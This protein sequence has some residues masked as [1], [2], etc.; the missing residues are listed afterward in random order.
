MEWWQ[1][2]ILGIVEGV[3]EFLPVSSTGHLIIAS[4][5]LGLD[6]EEIKDS[7]DA[8]NIIIQGAAIIAI[9]G[10]YWPRMMQMLRG[11]L[12]RDPK[13]LRLFTNIVIACLPSFILWPLLIGVA[14]EWLFSP[15]PVLAALFLGGLW[16][17]WIDRW[18]A[19][20]HEAGAAT[21]LDIDDL[22]WKHA[23]GIG[24]FQFFA[25]WP[26]TSRAMM[27]IAGATMLGMKPAKAAEFSFLLGL[28][29]IA[30]AT[31]YEIIGELRRDEDSGPGMLEDL[32]V[33][34]I[35]IGVVVT[36]IVA[37][38]AVKWFVAFLSRHG[39][40][41]FGWYRIILCII[42]GAMLFTGFIALE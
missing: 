35:L 9:V 28:P 34:P 5:L 24:C 30:G 31:L 42:M 23:L 32:G 2:V 12:G 13:G 36:I 19:K 38:A 17:I 27:T 20:R 14:K 29:T 26:G 3:T 39:L 1:A 4:T 7:V 33:I 8:F 41:A 40:A 15:W 21:D 10:L 37:A 25:I 16:M 11:L 22:T 18:R 6:G